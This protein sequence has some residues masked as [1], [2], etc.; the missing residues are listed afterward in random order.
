MVAGMEAQAEL[1]IIFTTAAGAAV[2]EAI[3]GLAVQAQDI[4]VRH[5]MR[6]QE[7]AAQVEVVLLDWWRMNLGLAAAVGLEF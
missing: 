2:R 1:Q 5:L 4:P 6:L 3:L 7:L